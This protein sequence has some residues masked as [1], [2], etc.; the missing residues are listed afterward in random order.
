MYSVQVHNIKDIVSLKET[1]RI[2]EK[3][4]DMTYF[5]SF[6]WYL[7]LGEI[8][9]KA[10]CT[11]PVK[12][13]V[14]SKSSC[15]VLIAPFIIIKRTQRLVNKKGVY[16]WGR[17]GW[18]D[19]LNLIYDELDYEAVDFLFTTIKKEYGILNFFLEQVIEGTSFYKY[20]KER[21]GIVEETSTDC[22]G[23]E[24]PAT[25]DD[26]HKRLSKHARQNL[27]TAKNR[28]DKDGIAFRYCFDD[29]LVDK[30]ICKAMRETR[31]VAKVH[32]G[33][34]S[35]GIKHKIINYVRSLL[36]IK[37]PVFLPFIVD[38]KSK[39]LT[40]YDGDKLCAFF[41]YGIDSFHKKVVLMAVGTNN[42]YARYS[43]GMLAMYSFITS[44]IESGIIKYVDFTR[45]NEPYKTALGGCKFLIKNVKFRHI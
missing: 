35:Q 29:S 30:E 11:L 25:I 37:Y 20:M 16:F 41:N 14:V 22:V 31:V 24:I 1:W 5:Q 18:S 44:N 42:V 7:M 33:S 23:L 27:R 10:N 43:P 12:L 9:S 3:G 15:P 38:S 8:Y 17:K 6:S 19:Y 2:L 28:A 45:G 36:E 32:K 21:K 39:M 13:F 40:V 4:Q 26:Y 34:A